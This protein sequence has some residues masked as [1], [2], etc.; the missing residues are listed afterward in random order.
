MQRMTAPASFFWKHSSKTER[1]EIDASV[2]QQRIPDIFFG[3]WNIS[4]YSADSVQQRIS[5]IFV[6]QFWWT[7][8]ISEQLS[9][10][11][12]SK[13]KLQIDTLSRFYIR[14]IQLQNQYLQIYCNADICRY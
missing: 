4:K 6:F 5:D 2:Q 10:S 3:L 13:V 9:F 7:I 1:R 14:D 11:I 8:Q 12:H